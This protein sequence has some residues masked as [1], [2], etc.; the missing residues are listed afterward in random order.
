MSG[1]P[2]KQG[3]AEETRTLPSAKAK[4]NIARIPAA[5]EVAQSSS[6]HCYFPSYLLDF[7]S[8]SSYHF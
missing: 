7:P 2:N 8:N 6:I 3:H 1:K 5:H 4:H